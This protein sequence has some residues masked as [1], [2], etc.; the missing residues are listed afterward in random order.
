MAQI[1]V[2]EEERA[3]PQRITIS[4]VLRLRSSFAELEDDLAWTTDY[5][6]VCAELKRFTAER[7]DRLIETLANAMAEHLLR[8]F[9]F[10]EVV[11]EVRKFALPETRHV[12][13]RVTQVAPPRA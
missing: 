4:L 3:Q 12:A 1:G 2:S 9:S 11:V 13:A 10:Q 5:A 7:R 6:A 8:R